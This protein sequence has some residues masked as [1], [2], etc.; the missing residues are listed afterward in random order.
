[1]STPFLS[2]IRVFSFQFPPKGW[3]LCNGQTLAINQNQVL[4]A[5]LGTT[6]GGNGTTNFQLPNLQ[7]RVPLHVGNGYTEGQVGGEQ[8]HTLI[9]SELPAHSHTLQATSGAANASAGANH[10]LAAAPIYAA[11]ADLTALQSS[12]LSSSGG[13]QPHNNMQ[14][15]LVL[16]FCIALSGIFP[17]RS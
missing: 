5:L 16:S 7:G 15:Y 13:S 12:A 14:P 8:S 6:Y 17:S 2:E 4:F 10:L 9:N 3:A 1:M 11:A